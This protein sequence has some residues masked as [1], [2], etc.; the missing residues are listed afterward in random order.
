VDFRPS[1]SQSPEPQVSHLDIYHRLGALEAKLD[2]LM[3]TVRDYSVDL[4]EAFKRI[5]KLENKLAWV[6]GGATI[7]GIVLPFVVTIA[8]NSFHVQI[9]PVQPTGTPQHLHR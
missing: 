7:A 9:R 4:N 3:N 1:V 2:A 5:S 8:T 6:L